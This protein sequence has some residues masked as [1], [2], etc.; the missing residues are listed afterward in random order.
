M[1]A[2]N[3]VH[4]PRIVAAVI[5]SPAVGYAFSAEGL[6]AVTVPSSSGVAKK[7]VT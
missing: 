2:P 3:W 4:D 5:A 7:A 6:S 1:A